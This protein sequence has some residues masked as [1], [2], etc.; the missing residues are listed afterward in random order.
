MFKK[1]KNPAQSSHAGPRDDIEPTC[2]TCKAHPET[3][4]HIL[5]DCTSLTLQRNKMLT[6]INEAFPNIKP[7]TKNLLTSKTLQPFV[8]SFLKCCT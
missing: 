1:R 7:T 5:H 6:R 3:A 8:L 2:S 4:L